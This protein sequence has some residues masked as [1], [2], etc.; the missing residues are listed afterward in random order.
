MQQARWE[1]MER[2]MRAED[3]SALGYGIQMAQHIVSLMGETELLCWYLRRAEQA[4]C[5]P[6]TR[7][8]GQYPAVLRQRLGG[9]SSGCL[10]AKG[11][12]DLLGYRAVSLVGSRDLN[13]ENLKFA[14]EA[15]RQAAL[16]GYVLVSGNAR[17]ADREAQ[18]ACLAAGGNVISVV[19]DELA[20][21]MPDDRV[22]YLSEDGF[23]L[24]FS[25]LRALHRNH[26]IHALGDRVLVAQASL[27]NGGTWDG[28]VKNLRFGWSPVHCFRDGSEAADTLIQMG[29][30]PLTADMLKDLSNLPRSEV[31]LFE[32]TI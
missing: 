31:S 17:G 16:Q 11:N 21:K 18:N 1:Y 2:E 15:G 22:L 10:W 7:V 23:D 9:Q 6:L 13:P 29:A 12:L 4:G 3:L 14:R 8:T 25:A 32:G 27:R 28:T 5:V 19:A 30:E 24:P 20:T 26:V